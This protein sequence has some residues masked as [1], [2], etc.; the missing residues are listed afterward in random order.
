MIKSI[1]VDKKMKTRFK[2]KRIRN[3]YV[4]IISIYPIKSVTALY[5]VPIGTERSSI[6]KW[7]YFQYL[8]FQPENAK[9]LTMK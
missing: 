5:L 1:M 8:I 6:K 4:Y 7:D 2:M 3:K 9:A